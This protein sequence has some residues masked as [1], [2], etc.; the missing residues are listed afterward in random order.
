MLGYTKV[1]L[2]V[3]HQCLSDPRDIYLAQTMSKKLYLNGVVKGLA[4]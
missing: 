2:Q 4:I 1:M 3:L